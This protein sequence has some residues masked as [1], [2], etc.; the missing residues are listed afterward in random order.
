M[1][2]DRSGNDCPPAH[3]GTMEDKNPSH[4]SHFL[5]IL[6][7]G[8]FVNVQ[9]FCTKAEHGIPLLLPVLPGRLSCRCLCKKTLHRVPATC[10]GPVFQLPAVIAG[11][12]LGGQECEGKGKKGAVF[13]CLF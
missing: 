12:H 8:R 13:R 10:T 3:R 2:P 5:L 4:L 11:R 7:L 1:S 6:R 9:P